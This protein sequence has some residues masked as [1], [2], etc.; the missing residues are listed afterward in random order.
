M[1]YHI[2]TSL[3]LCKYRAGCYF[4]FPTSRASRIFLF[5]ECFFEQWESQLGTAAGRKLREATLS[6]NKNSQKFI[7][8]S[9]FSHFPTQAR[10]ENARLRGGLES[11]TSEVSRLSSE[12]AEAARRLG[13][14]E[15]RLSEAAG[16]RE[17]DARR[18]EALTEKCAKMEERY[19]R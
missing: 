15:E 17:E 18:L 2:Q 16:R 4:L 14:A 13:E 10:E 5:C 9:S 6:K 1:Y 7:F 11:A 12:A 3:L 8:G 19:G